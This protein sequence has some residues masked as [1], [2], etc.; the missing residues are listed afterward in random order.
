MTK[1]LKAD[2]ML[3]W[4][5]FFWGATYALTKIAVEMFSPMNLI[6]LRFSIAFLAMLPVFWKRLVRADRKTVRYSAILSV[7]LFLVFT[8]M[9]Y[10][11][12]YTS[13]SNAAFLAGL[14]VIFIAVGSFL[15]LGKKLNK[16]TWVCVLLSL[17]GVCL[18]TITP[19]LRF[20]MGV[21]DFLSLMVSVLYAVYVLL[22]DKYTQEVDSIVLGV[23]QLG[24][25]GV[26]ATGMSMAT[27]H[28]LLPRDAKSLWIIF[29]LSILCTAFAYVVQTVAQKYTSPTH[30]G[31]ILSLEIV[32][33]GI[34]AYFLVGE[35]LRPINYVGAVLLMI[36]VILMEIDVTFGKRETMN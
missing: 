1:T 20:N 30:T 25:V 17:L 27:E 24:F 21:G 19:E 9:T 18:L 16:K 15:F 3:V 4:V 29:V 13:A 34:F 28:F 35:V 7:V 10:G 12:K 11:V 6:A 8:S 31:I 14:T 32:F 33:S 2:I 5:T 26:I 22:L 36:A 23:L